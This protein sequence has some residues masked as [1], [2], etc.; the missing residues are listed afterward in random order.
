MAEYYLISQLP[1]LDAVGEGAPL[2]I[3]EEQFLELCKNYLS[4]RAL[5]E[6]EKITLTPKIEQESFGSALIEK[7]NEGERNLRLALAGARAERM[8]KSFES[9]S[10]TYPIEIIKTVNDALDMDDPLAA[11]NLLLQYRLGFL[12][13][14][15]PMDSFSK[16]YVFY[17]ALKLKLISRIRKFDTARG[18]AAY[19]RIYNSILSGDALED[20]K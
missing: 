11:E 3:T 9:R 15:R 7:F 14:L 6:I 1:S 2:P 4:K 13:S 12:E 20:E 17:Y 16:E 8:N 10:A 19:R 5:S 18:E